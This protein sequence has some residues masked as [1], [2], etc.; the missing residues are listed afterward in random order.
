MTRKNKQRRKMEK[1]AKRDNMLIELAKTTRREAIARE[2]YRDEESGKVLGYFTVPDWAEWMQGEIDKNPLTYWTEV[3]Q[4]MIRLGFPIAYEYRRGHYFGLPGEQ[5]KNVAQQANNIITRQNTM[6]KHV[7][8]IL[9]SGELEVTRPYVDAGLRDGE[10]NYN[11]LVAAVR[12]FKLAFGQ[13]FQHSL[14]E[15]LLNAINGKPRS[16]K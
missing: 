10:G 12:D 9:E 1:H 16:D 11:R 6:L 14:F 13:S 4:H 5:G 8:H 15:P 7:E 3:K 2:C